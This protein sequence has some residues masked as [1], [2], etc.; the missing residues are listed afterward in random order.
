M[1]SFDSVF[2][3]SPINGR[4]PNVVLDKSLLI[5]ASKQELRLLCASANVLMIETLFMEL[6]T[7]DTSTDKKR[8][9]SPGASQSFRK[10]NVLFI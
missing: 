2:R 6:M 8:D 1:N 7:A 5:S 4:K 3:L 9:S 10:K